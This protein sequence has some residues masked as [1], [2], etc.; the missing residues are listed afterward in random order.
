VDRWMITV[1]ALVLMAVPRGALASGSG[2]IQHPS[3]SPDARTIV[4]SAMGDLWALDASGG[5]AARLT[6]HPGIEGRSAFSAD[7][8]ALAFESNRDGATNLY[9][10]RVAGSGARTTLTDIR[11]VTVSDRS[12]RLGGFDRS[13]DAL[14]FSSYLNRD[15][16]RLPEMYRAPL[17]GGAITPITRAHGRAPVAGAD[18]T[19]VFTRGYDA[20][21]R[22]AYRGPGNADI[23]RFDPSDGSFERITA[24]DGHDID[25]FVRPDGSIVYLSAR[26]GGYNLRLLGEG[27]TD[28]GFRD[29][30]RL[31]R[32]EP[33][34]SGTT[35]AHG[36]RDLGVSGDGALAVFVVWNTLYTLDLNDR[37]AEPNEIR[38]RFGADSGRDASRK[39]DLSKQVDEAV[40]H[41]SGDAIAIVAR[42]E[43][44]VR[45]TKD[46]HPTRRVTDTPVRERDI[47]WSPDGEF[48]Y[49]TADDDGSLGSIHRARVTLSTVDLEPEDPET[50][51]DDDASDDDASEDADEASTAGQDDP[52]EAGDG[53][54][55][56]GTEEDNTTD[57]VDHG[58][59]WG[60]ALRFGVEP[61][62]VG[63]SHCYAPT[64][65][66]DG[67]SLLYKRLRGDVILRDLDTGEERVIVESWSDPGVI[68]AP[69]SVHILVT[70]TDL[71]FNADIFLY[72]TRAGDEGSLP[73]GINLTR[74][75]DVDHSPRISSDGKVLTFLSDRDS[76]NWSWDVYAI[77]LDRALDGMPRYE[78]KAY[79]D[80][81][82]EAAKKRGPLDPEDPVGVEPMDFD[83]RDAYLR[84]RRLTSTPGSE[85]NLVLSPGA[86]RIAFTSGGAFVSVDPWGA[87][88]KT[89]HTGSVSGARVS[90]DGSR[91]SFV[92][93]GQA[94]TAPI[95]GGKLT[96]HG[97]DADIVVERHAE[98]AQMFREAAGRFGQDFY[99]PTLKG[100]D[101]DAITQRY[102]DLAL[103]TRTNQAFQRVLDLMMGEVDGSH[104]GVRGGDGFS[105]ANE[106]TGY[107]GI[108]ATPI[109]RGY[110]VDTMDD[111]PGAGDILVAVGDTRLAR[112]GADPVD[113]NRVMRGTRGREV[114]VEYL[115]EDPEAEADAG[116]DSEDGRWVTR[117]GLVTPVGHGAYTVIR[118]RQEVLDRRA[119]VDRL[120]QGR[121]GYL[122]IRAMGASSVR[123]FERDLYAA[124]I[125][126]E[127][128][129]IDVR[130]N[131]GGWTTDILLASLTAPAHAY[132]VPR[133]ADPDEV[134]FDSYPRDRRLIYSY[135]R[136]IVVLINENSFSNAEI[137]SHAIKTIGRGRLVGTQTFG[138]VIST[139][140]FTLIDGTA[141]RRPFRGWYLPDG[142]DMENNGAVPDLAVEQTPADEAAGRDP[143]LEAAV[144]DLLRTVR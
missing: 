79:H 64:P 46:D 143:Q 16:Y 105:A 133:G 54:E 39:M 15:I 20:P 70:D 135:A 111:G 91:V 11:R 88:R 131:G 48:L 86:E 81:A 8:S 35:I 95:A 67:A 87:E 60:G 129:V 4:V 94:H 44:F 65:S 12:Q 130:D 51:G 121:L 123:E 73:E 41:P 72:D 3:V 124:A 90:L 83:A 89:I 117:F 56:D 85:N 14:L 63:A 109:A 108:D 57:A 78:L 69:D 10:A 47:A 132:T 139:G 40:L 77:H 144:K 30:R 112:T 49:F 58:A 76:D 29:G 52:E 80:E 68:W 110:P 100:L 21:Q 106:Q 53:G 82:A 50:P 113:L 22:R 66:P 33:G 114:L 5:V 17:D 115:R 18:G 43:L 1:C 7:G 74:H 122:H 37:G 126:K 31:T 26:E 141:V 101:W 59:R 34:E 134:A 140:S 138:G 116:T 19:I 32:F 25:P 9:I 127:G 13:G 45:S 99:H 103:A 28:R 6:A 2:L 119:E 84:V 102:K 97:I 61:V 125:G 96:T 38:V 137:F 136:P 24:F 71:D 92:S 42:G 128:L 62:V 23:W 55:D 27:E 36:V 107:L 98:R 120:S 104:T 75:P 142:T 93:G 118:Y